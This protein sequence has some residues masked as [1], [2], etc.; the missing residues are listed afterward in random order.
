MRFQRTALRHAKTHNGFTSSSSVIHLSLVMLKTLLCFISSY[1]ANSTCTLTNQCPLFPLVCHV[2]NPGWARVQIS[3]VLKDT[4]RNDFPLGDDVELAAVL[5]LFYVGRATARR[6]NCPS[7]PK[8]CG[9][10]PSGLLD[11]LWWWSLC[12]NYSDRAPDNYA[13]AT[14]A[15]WVFHFSLDC[16]QTGKE[17]NENFVIPAV[18]L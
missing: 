4:F 17:Q 5:L 9:S 1:I 2:E 3:Q 15:I 14:E 6:L 13:S 16:E 10:T 18:L 12:F 7:S 8:P 11:F